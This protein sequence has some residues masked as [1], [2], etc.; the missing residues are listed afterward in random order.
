MNYMVIILIRQRK[1]SIFSP[2]ASQHY[3]L[4]NDFHSYENRKEYG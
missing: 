4:S 2:E 3:R 1:I